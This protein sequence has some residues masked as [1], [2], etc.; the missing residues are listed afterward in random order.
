MIKI[1]C[2]IAVLMPFSFAQAV[3]IKVNAEYAQS[4]KNPGE[5]EFRITDPCKPLPLSVFCNDNLSRVISID[6]DIDRPL[7][8]GGTWWE[9]LFYHSFPGEKTVQLFN[10]NGLSV[11]MKFAMTHTGYSIDNPFFVVSDAATADV[12]SKC[13]LV[14]YVL[15]VEGDKTDTLFYAI[16]AS[17][18]KTGGV[19]YSRDF[20]YWSQYPSPHVGKIR[21]FYIGYKLMPVNVGAISNGTYKGKLSLSVGSTRDIDFTNATYRYPTV[22]DLEFSLVVRNHLK[23]VFPPAGNKVVLQPDGGWHHGNKTPSLSGVMPVQITSSIPYWIKLECQYLSTVDD[24]CQIKNNKN[25][26]LVSMSIYKKSTKGH[27]LLSPTLKKNFEKNEPLSNGMFLFKVN[28]D[29]VKDMINYPGS[30]Y[31]GAVT[32]IMDAMIEPVYN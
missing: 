17:N 20:S 14:D 16:D 19:C 27:V 5:N 30:T 6:S 8:K 10:E 32:I 12:N 25:S 29:K 22:V 9:R 11:T 4:L 7:A 1:I 28:K 24:S 13:K 26:S 15:S 3:V 31:K 21:K 18:Q 23:V 2:L